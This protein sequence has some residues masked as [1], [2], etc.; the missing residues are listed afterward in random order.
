M[1]S[2]SRYGLLLCSCFVLAAALSI[3]SMR[4]ANAQRANLLLKS[5][6]TA[7]NQS[8]YTALSTVTARYGDHTMGSQARVLHAPGKFSITYISGDRKGLQSGYNQHWFWRRES[9]GAPMQAYAQVKSSPDEM[10]ARRFALMM[11]N[12]H[13]FVVGEDVVNG[14][15][16]AIV[17]L[18]PVAHI[19]GA[20][21][22]FKRIWID[23]EC[24]LTLRSDTFNY[25]RQLVMNTVISD[26]NLSP[27][28]DDSAFASPEVMRKAARNAN[29]SGEEMGADC[30][31][32]ERITGLCVPRPAYLPP[33]FAFDGVGVHRC[34]E[35]KA[36]REAALARFTDGLNTL[37]LF[38]LPQAPAGHDAGAGRG[39][40]D[41]GPGSMVM[42]QQ[43][44]LQ[45]IAVADLPPVTLRRVLDSIHLA[46][47]G[48]L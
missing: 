23:R 2:L 27:V 25:Q 40:C 31:A 16:A 44:G 46:R 48:K 9:P 3:W 18:R 33:G 8:T 26:L 32:V 15:P 42:A 17:E 20:R 19:D 28:I 10:A 29:F 35:G 30:A 14:R 39:V 36:T 11:K 24:G 4:R 6:Y 41:F 13:G 21:G 43:N 5:T 1:R 47:S 38:V 12:Y 37:T 45:A 22:P 7:D 34:S